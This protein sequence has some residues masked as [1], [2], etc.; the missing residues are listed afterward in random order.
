MK[1][2]VKISRGFYAIALM[3]YGIQQ[4]IYGDFR[5]VFLPPWQTNLIL[6][7]LWAYLF[8]IFLI[9]IGFA[10]I[11]GKMA[12]E[13][14]LILGGIFLASFCFVHI[15]YELTSEPNSSWHLGVWG[16]ALKALALAGGAFVIAGTFH[17]DSVD[18][19]NKSAIFKFLER[20]IPYGE[21]F[22]SITMMCF[23]TTHFL[24]PN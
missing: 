22:F 10:V 6:L 20:I 17:E 21:I 3:I 13:A 5:N 15:P 24:Y 11:T 2:I 12:R 7:P 4:F 14:L 16:N 1:Y 18:P 8:G 19:Q 9:A 23:G